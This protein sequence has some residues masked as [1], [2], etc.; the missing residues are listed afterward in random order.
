MTKQKFIKKYLQDIHQIKTSCSTICRRLK[1]IQISRKKVSKKKVLTCNTEKIKSEFVRKVKKHGRPIYCLD[2]TGFDVHVHP[3]Y[4]YSEKGSKCYY[5]SKVRSNPK[6]LH[7][8]FIISTGGIVNYKLYG[9]PINQDKFIDFLSSCDID[10][11]I[12]M[13]NY[14]VHHS[15]KLSI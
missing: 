1:H 4:G 11:D 9:E 13:D 5:N 15:K 2:E 3:N 14:S 12:L 6:K 10:G 7:G 8:I